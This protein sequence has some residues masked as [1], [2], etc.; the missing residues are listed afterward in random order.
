[1][2]LPSR[3][4]TLALFLLVTSLGANAA[5]MRFEGIAPPEAFVF[6]VTPYTEAG[7][8]LTNSLG[9]DSLTDGLFDSECLVNDNGSDFFGWCS[10]TNECP[11]IV[12]TLTENSGAIFDFISFDTAVL[13]AGN[14]PNIIEVIGHR[15]AGRPLSAIIRQT[16]DWTTYV[17][18]WKRVIR[19]DFIHGPGHM[20]GP[21]HAIDNLIM[22]V[23][24]TP[25]IPAVPAQ[26]THPGA[27]KATPAIRA[28]PR[29]PGN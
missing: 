24:T 21:N 1:M 27:A 2:K 22:S 16:D 7:F 9:T 8:T 25:A 4:A 23:V 3:T 12:I 29:Q 28:V 13:E 11:S 14:G 5:T 6:G 19:V 17:L 26:P 18:G 20:D 15:A 10:D